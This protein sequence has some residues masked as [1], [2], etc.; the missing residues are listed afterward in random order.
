MQT[1]IGLT[2]LFFAIWVAV[3]L[4]GNLVNLDVTSPAATL[5]LALM[6]LKTNDVGVAAGFVIPDT[7]FALDYVRP[8]FILLRVLARA[9][10]MWD[11]LVPT[12]AWV[13][14]QLPR[15]LRGPLSKLMAS[16]KAG[17]EDIDREALAQAHI[18]AISGACLALG[19]RYAGSANAAAYGVLKHYLL[20]L[21][22]AKK[23][24]PDASQGAEATWGRLDKQALEACL[25]LV[26][27]SLAVVMAGTGHLPTFKLLRGMRL[28]LQPAPSQAA[29][30]GLSHGNHMAVGMALGFLFMGGGTQT[31]STSNES[32]AA[33]LIAIFPHFPTISTDHRC[34]LQ[35]FR[36]LYAL[37]A[38][39][40]C[41]EAVDVDTRQPVSVPV[42]ITLDPTAVGQAW[43]QTSA[44]PQGNQRLQMDGRDGQDDA[45]EAADPQLVFTRMTPC[46]L[47]ELAQVKDIQVCGPRYW[48]FR[49]SKRAPGTANAADCPLSSLY[50]SRN[51]FVQRKTG[52][53]SYGDD[54]TGVR[55]ILSRA[56]TPQVASGKQ[57]DTDSFDLVHLCA[58][59]SASP[60][61][62]SFAKRFC[63]P[64][65][66]GDSFVEGLG[67]A[68]GPQ[69]EALQAFCRQALAECMGQE[70]AALLQPYL[71]FHTLVHSPAI[72]GGSGVMPGAAA[73]GLSVQLWS[74][75]LAL[76]YYN[77]CVRGGAALPVASSSTANPGASQPEEEDSWQPLLRPDFLQGLWQQLES[78]WLAAGF[79][80][81]PAQTMSLLLQQYYQAGSLPA[82]DDGSPAGGG[83]AFG[84]YLSV[85]ELPSPSAL[86]D[87][88]AAVQQAQ[89][90]QDQLLEKLLAA[91]GP[92]A[93]LPVLAAALPGTPTSALHSAAAC[94]AV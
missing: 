68:G 3:V 1:V 70:K 13:Q 67:G 63:S 30:G 33:L 81:A 56:F 71:F 73:G 94:M 8:N 2:I 77:G 58:T 64:Q 69:E 92:H 32:V 17:T 89:A 12:E 91:H 59:F 4:E 66:R 79:R 47:P 45:D 5:A 80:H 37:A 52:T 28:R 35:A 15:L 90:A 87:A 78:T 93:L 82:Y 42:R 76:A 31:F 23:T 6:F 41:L 62:T 36:H 50:A 34:H 75:K 57:G 26:A 43:Q 65:G 40:R 39:P 38:E 10:I 83:E 19:I 88:S 7:H 21:L 86:R 61:V 60:F 24:A 72:A 74:L 49:V 20:Y 51:L 27:L 11:K 46:L 85:N 44:S 18:M 14:Q 53:L 16:T 55:S 29:A 48:T 22:A 25:D 54:P 9:L 84:A